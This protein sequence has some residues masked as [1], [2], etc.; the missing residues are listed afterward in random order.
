LEISPANSPFF[1]KFPLIHNF[2]HKNVFIELEDCL[3]YGKLIHYEFG[4]KGKLHKPT[5][6]IVESQVGK[7]II[8][9]GWISIAEGIKE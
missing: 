4:R 8:R 1:D 3:V 2:L 7:V 5:I 9:G 6:L